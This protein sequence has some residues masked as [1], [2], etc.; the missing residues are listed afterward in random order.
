[1][2]AGTRNLFCSDIDKNYETIFSINDPNEKPSEG[3]LIVG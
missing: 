2:G 1:M 3:S